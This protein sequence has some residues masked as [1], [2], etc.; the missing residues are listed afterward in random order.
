M[1]R[2][3]RTREERFERLLDLA[4]EPD[5]PHT[6]PDLDERERTERESWELIAEGRRALVVAPQVR[7]LGLAVRVAAAVYALELVASLALLALD[8]EG[9]PALGVAAATKAALLGAICLIVAADVSRFMRLL[10]LLAI[11]EALTAGLLGIAWWLHGAGDTLPGNLGDRWLLP[12]LI[13][14]S[15][16]LAGGLVWIRAAAGRAEDLLRYLG[17]NEAETLGAFAEVV[18]D[19]PLVPARTITHNVDA[20]LSEAATPRKGDVVQRLRRLSLLPLRRL[21]PP[22]AVLRPS[23]RTDLVD[24]HMAHPAVRTALQLVSLGQYGDPRTAAALGVERP[25]PPEARLP[26]RLLATAPN[27]EYDVAI[28]G[29]GAAGATLAGRFAEAGMRVVLVEAGPAAEPARVADPV[30]RYVD[31]CR[32]AALPLVLDR[33]VAELAAQCVGGGLALSHGVL[34]RPAQDWRSGDI[35]ADAIEPCLSRIEHELRDGVGDRNWEPRIHAHDSHTELRRLDPGA[36]QPAWSLLAAGQRHGVEIV[37]DCAVREIVHEHGRVLGLN[38]TRRSSELLFVDARAVVVAAGPGRSVQLLR[39]SHL[40]GKVEPDPP[41]TIAH[42]RMVGVFEEAIPQAGELMAAY[43]V[44]GEDRFVLQARR[45]DPL[46]ES[47]LLP[48]PFGGREY[49]LR[50]YAHLLAL[51]AVTGLTLEGG[52][53]SADDRARVVRRLR[54]AGHMLFAAGA[55]QVVAPAWEL[56]EFSEPR[57]LDAWDGGDLWLGI[58]YPVGGLTRAVDADLR[59]GG[60]ENLRVCD[61]SVLAPGI[62]VAPQLTVMALADHLADR[63]LGSA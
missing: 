24:R 13:A 48:G 37:S 12:G 54:I 15:A 34:A 58:G 28:V 35:S 60:I 29:S 43:L 25:S 59:V 18:L 23:S 33:T 30:R 53:L 62:D 52:R 16:I 32:D 61:A 42:P 40:L 31:L 5:D 10:T 7:R 3:S 63:I 6:E 49:L 38:C 1:A 56:R 4:L 36:L 27:R 8:A 57:E 14:L 39:R 26:L 47:L 19:D 46:T 22:F 50:R 2:G 45:A 11:A 9:A 51:E 21:L 55:Q 20:Y 44:E 17:R 41:G